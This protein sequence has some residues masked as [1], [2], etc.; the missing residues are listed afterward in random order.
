MTQN[1]SIKIAIDGPAGAGK[2][3][4][5][6]LVA[7]R[8][9][10]KYLDTGAMY[11]AITLAVLRAGIRTDDTASIITLIDSLKLDIQQD[12]KGINHI[13]L[14]G[15]NV[16]EPIREQK[17]SDAVSDVSNILAVRKLL[18]EKQREIA[19]KGGVVLDG[20]DIG[21][22]VLPNAELK[23]FLIA[24]LAVRAQRRYLELK[25]KKSNIS[26]AD[27]TQAIDIRDNKDANNL[28]GPLK[29]AADAITVNTDYL[30]ANDV[31]EKII[32]LAKQKINAP[33]KN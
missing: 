32:E 16:S 12:S 26:L 11:R 27:L 24:S 13:I 7:Q 28:Y 31:V 17:V 20:R 23:I 6:R 15:E 3:T 9:G 22:V 18:I 14:D 21:T 2:S 8:L 30:L 5:A 1:K 29:A 4:V 33:A 10:Y 25:D 19:S